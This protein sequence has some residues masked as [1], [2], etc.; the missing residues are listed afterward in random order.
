MK[1]MRDLPSHDRPREKLASCGAEALTDVEL[2]T[3]SSGGA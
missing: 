1:K 3:L 2:V